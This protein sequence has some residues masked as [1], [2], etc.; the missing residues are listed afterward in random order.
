MGDI[1]IVAG[2]DSS[3]NTT[4]LQVAAWDWNNKWFNYYERKGSGEHNAGG[5]TNSDQIPFDYVVYAVRCDR[6]PACD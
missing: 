1:L 3:S 4:F 5:L 6:S 2:P